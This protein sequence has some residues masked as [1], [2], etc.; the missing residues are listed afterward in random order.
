VSYVVAT[1]DSLA[2][3]AKD[4]AAMGSA[5]SAANAAAAHSTTSLLAAGADEVSTRIAALF[6]A[7][8]LEYQAVSSQGAQFNEQF[9]LGLAANAN[10]YLTTEIANAEQ[11]LWNAV[12]APAQTLLGRPLI[13]NGANATTPGGAGA[14]RVAPASMA[15]LMA[16]PAGRPLG[17]FRFRAQRQARGLRSPVQGRFTIR[18]SSLNCPI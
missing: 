17:L 6:G 7:H 16:V 9:V 13:G 12:N 18:T 11:S 3:A 5:V 15:R 14:A 1:P 2:T 8:G 10:A 4:L